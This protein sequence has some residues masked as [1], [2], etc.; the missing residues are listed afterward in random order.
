MSE[1][2]ATYVGNLTAAVADGRDGQQLDENLAGFLPV[3]DLAR[4]CP[5]SRMVCHIS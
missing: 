5:T 3:P 1:K 4:Q 2:I